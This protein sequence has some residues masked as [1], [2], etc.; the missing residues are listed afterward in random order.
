MAISAVSKVADFPDHHDVRV[1]PQ[2]GAQGVGEGQA[3][4]GFHGD[5]HHAGELV[6]HRILDGDD[7]PLRVVH[8]AQ[9]GIEAG[10]FTRTG[11][12]G[13]QDDAVGQMQQR[14]DLALHEGLHARA[15]RC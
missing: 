7:A 4:L 8:L 13:D 6:F 2:D 11:G 5:L 15:W 10:G 1:G 9:E 12:A 14:F 3:D